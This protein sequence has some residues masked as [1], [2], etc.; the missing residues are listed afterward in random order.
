[1]KFVCV[2][3]TH[4]Q[5]RWLEL[6]RDRAWPSAQRAGFDEIVMCHQPDGTLATARNEGAALAVERHLADYLVFLDA[7]D[8]LW[9]GFVETLREALMFWMVDNPE[10]RLPLLTPAVQYVR[11]RQQPTPKIWP[12]MPIEDG[13]WMVIGT[14]IPSS[15]FSQVGGFKEWPLYEDWCLWQRAMKAGCEPVDVPD[16]VYVAHTDPR[17]RNRAPARSVKL[18]THNAIRRANYPELYEEE[19]R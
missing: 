7:D 11:G 17:S 19:G 1:V 18:A 15:V 14:A 5:A 3:A 9:T 8:E 16:A 4:G 6:A 10:R 12:R 2:I 13:N